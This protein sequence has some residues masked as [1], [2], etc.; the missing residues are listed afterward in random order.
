MTDDT[1]DEFPPDDELPDDPLAVEDID[2]FTVDDSKF[3][4]LDEFARAEWVAT[5][6]AR[7]RVRTVVKYLDDDADIGDI[8]ETAIVSVS[9]T[10]SMD[11]DDDVD[12]D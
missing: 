2:P 6:S 1:P 3:S 12:E 4:T 11:Y 5:T 10:E 8:A 9:E 7:E